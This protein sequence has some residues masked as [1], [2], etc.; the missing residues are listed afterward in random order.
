MI[1]MGTCPNHYHGMVLIM[2]IACLSLLPVDVA[3][4]VSDGQGNEGR[5]QGHV[6]D[7]RQ[8]ESTTAAEDH[9]GV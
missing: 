4:A 1:I 3:V 2:I 9:D 7:E 5:L 8:N 6:T